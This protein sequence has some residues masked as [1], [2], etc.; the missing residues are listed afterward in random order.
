MGEH[1]CHGAFA[2]KNMDPLDQAVFVNFRRAGHLNRTMFGKV[3]GHERPGLP[4]RTMMLLVLSHVPDG[5]TQREVAEMLHVSPPTVTVMLQKMEAD[6]A[7]ERWTDEADQ[8]LTRIRL[9]ADGR[10]A[11]DRVSEKLAKAVEQSVGRMPADDRRE[12]ARLLGDFADNIQALIERG[13][14]E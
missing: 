3:V 6:G 1:N 14:E 13:L 7:I 12:L 9:T 11:A 5:I 8:R 2:P 4:G 10:G